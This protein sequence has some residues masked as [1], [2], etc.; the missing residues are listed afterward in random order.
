M[1]LR[2]HEIAEANHR[3]LNPFTES[4]LD[5]LGELCRLRA[6]MR[7]LDLACG[8]GEMLARWSS[9]YGITGVGV[10]LSDYFLLAA[11]RRAAEL[12]VADRLT[13]VSGDA[14]AHVAE[15][16]AFDVVSC[17]G[18]TWIGGGLAGTLDLMK[19]AL[20]PDGLLLVGEPYW[21]DEP[22]AEAVEALGAPDSVSLSGTLERFEAA[23]CELIEMVHADHDSWDRYVAAQ[24]RTI[25]DWLRANSG[26][27][28]A[29]AM[30]DFAEQS[31]KS[32]MAYGRRY[33]GWGVFMLRVV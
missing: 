31:R 15:E 32:Y 3:I 20:A 9:T 19:R 21:I 4:K 25:A 28:E 22:P 6:G 10:D 30:R 18:A 2:H 24:W 26:D 11:E 33:F 27:P 29:Q 23:G 5:L 16:G 14:G 17:I 1:S 7:Q 12:R 8:K 13:F